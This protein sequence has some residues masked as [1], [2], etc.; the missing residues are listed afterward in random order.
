MTPLV[1][2]INLSCEYYL[3]LSIRMMS[4][5]HKDAAE[6]ADKG[7]EREPQEAKC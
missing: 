4:V 2:D 6:E 7:D 1:K 3:A 5:W